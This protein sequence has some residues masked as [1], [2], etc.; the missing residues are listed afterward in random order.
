MLPEERSMIRTTIEG[1]VQTTGAL[2]GE[3]IY[4]EQFLNKHSMVAFA[5]IG[6]EVPTD[7]KKVWDPG[8]AK[9]HL[10]AHAVAARLPQYDVVLGGATT[11]DVTVRNIN[12][13]YGVHWLSKTLNIAPAQM[14]YVGDALYPDGN[15]EPVIATGIQV[16]GTSGPAE[17]E[18]IIDELLATLVIPQIV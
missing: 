2:Q 3:V 13:A 14:L 5:M 9:R 7:V 17:T 11:L 1:A 10:L 16:R 8:N 12:K 18:K 4:G 15:D 6:R